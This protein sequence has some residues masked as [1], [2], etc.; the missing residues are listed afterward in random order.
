MTTKTSGDCVQL[1]YFWK[2]LSVDF[3]VIHLAEEPT[4]EAPKPMAIDVKPAL[5]EIK[6]EE[7]PS[8]SSSL[9]IDKVQP[10]SSRPAS[11][12][13]TQPPQ[14]A[15]VRAHVCDMPDCSAVSTQTGFLYCIIQS[16]N[17]N[18]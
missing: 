12:P 1:Y 5:A 10:N 17:C 3:K 14:P 13:T 18:I 7:P 16:K 8:R 11:A 15:E 2:K 6:L 9:P 4:A